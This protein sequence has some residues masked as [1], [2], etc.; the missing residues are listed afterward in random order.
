[1]VLS[2]G[3]AR[4]H[5]PTHP[6]CAMLLRVISLQAWAWGLPAKLHNRVSANEKTLQNGVEL[7]ACLYV[8][9]H[10]SCKKIKRFS[11]SHS[12]TKWYRVW[13]ML[14]CLLASMQAA[15]KREKEPKSF[16]ASNLQ[17]GVNLDGACLLTCKLHKF[18]LQEMFF[19]AKKRSYSN[20]SNFFSLSEDEFWNSLSFGVVCGR[21]C[22]F[23]I[24]MSFGFV[25]GRL[26]SFKICISV[27]VRLCQI[28]QFLKF[29]LSFGFICGRLCSLKICISFWVCLWQ[30]V[31]FLKFA[32]SF[33]FICGRL[34]SLKF[35]I[36]FWVCL[37]QI[38]Q[39]LKFASSFGFICGRLCSLKICISFLGLSLENCG[40]LKFA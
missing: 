16:S 24:C 25:C 37:W 39:F 1:M 32:L 10:P 34:F 18:S 38:V 4:T 36:S 9:F 13:G 20:W 7:V 40:V 11:V 22:S 27:W 21:L 17:S 5:P 30:I 3:L 6:S 29:A 8:C 26:W 15:K 2:L 33:G 23:E 14:V 35:C 31:Q 28:V 19:H 12:F